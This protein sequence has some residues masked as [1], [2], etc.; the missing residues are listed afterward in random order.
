MPLS[1][2]W[3]IINSESAREVELR[4]KSAVS[5][6]ARASLVE[7]HAGADQGLGGPLAVLLG[8]AVAEL[9]E[10]LFVGVDESLDPILETANLA[11]LGIRLR[12]LVGLGHQPVDLVLG[13]PAGRVDLDRLRLVGRHV[14]RRD[15]HDAVRIDR[16]GDFDLRHAAR[17]RRDSDQLE[18]PEG[19]VLGGDLALALENVHFDRVLV[20]DH[21]GEDL[22]V[23]RGDGGVALDEPDEQAA[24]G[25]DAERQRGDVEQDQVLDVAADDAAL[26]GGADR[27]HL[28]GVDVA[29][30][31]AP[32]DALDRLPDQR[33]AGLPAH[34]Q[35]LVDV[36]GGEP[37]LLDRVA[38]GTFRARHQLGHEGLRRRS[39]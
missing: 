30:R 34:Q 8:Q 10:H 2:T 28:V 39:A 37:G 4:S 6:S 20:V 9:G 11:L 17:C 26:D 21:G 24:V 23:L 12:E 32:E 15:A 19:T 22:R 29:V 38:A 5:R 35:D 14:A 18:A 1:P 31:R 16:E 25:L 7:R 27:H 13:E 33:R 3:L 36:L